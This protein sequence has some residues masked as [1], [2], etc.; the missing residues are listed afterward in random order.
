M[1]QSR[2]TKP[3][4][5]LFAILLS[6]GG[7]AAASRLQ[8]G[9]GS[10]GPADRWGRAVLDGRGQRVNHGPASTPAPSALPTGT[11]DRSSDRSA[12]FGPVAASALDV[13]LEFRAATFGTG[14]GE[15]GMHAADLDGDGALEVVVA[16]SAGGFGPASFWY[17]LSHRGS[18]YGQTWVSSAFPDSIYSLA[19]A[20]I[21]LDPA[22]E[23]LVGTG[24]KVHVYDGNTRELQW[25]I[26]TTASEVRSLQVA[27]VDGDTVPEIVFCDPSGLYVYDARTGA[28]EVQSLLDGC[29]S[30]AAGNVD[31]DPGLEIVVGNGTATGYVLDGATRATEWAYPLGFGAMVRLG[32]LDGD[33]IA[34]IVGAQAWSQ[35]SVLDAVTRVE[36]DAVYPSHDIGAVAVADVEGDGPNEVLYGD[37]QWGEV[38][39]LNGATLAQKWAADN[40]EHG[41]TNVL[42][43]D[44]DDDGVNELLW[45]AGH[46][47]SGPDHLYVVDTVTGLT[48]WESLD[49]NGPYYGLAHGDVDGN[50]RPDFLFT[51]FESDSGYGDGLY[52]VYRAVNK[53]LRFVSPE[54]TDLNW[55]GLVRVQVANVDSD[56]QLEVL[57]GT[58]HLYKGILICYDGLRTR[59]SGGT[60][61]RTG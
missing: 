39:V 31:A 57:I 56:P 53:R 24:D 59:S 29:M 45:G 40:P 52:F 23:V 17:V 41:V 2:R 8:A 58:S 61:W 48:E 14:I 25:V 47:S 27:D 19:V 32:D 36:E 15:V 3:L 34:E 20:A 44:T 11:A 16:A 7:S 35:I 54:P 21:D 9:A 30:V 51:S 49:F 46:T 10:G 26:D 12:A 22:P 43:A 18:G 4:V 55:T 1:G 28:P 38:H 42:V 33:A 6:F 5:C 50:G 60:K 37:G 13:R